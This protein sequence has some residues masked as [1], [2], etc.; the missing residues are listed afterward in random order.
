MSVDSSGNQT[1]VGFSE[2]ASISADRRVVT[3]QSRATNLVANDTNNSWDIFVHEL[4][5]TQPND[6]ISP[7]ITASA[8]TDSGADYVPDTW[9][10]EDVKVTLSA[11]DN[12]G[13][14]GLKDIR[15]SATGAQSISET[16]YDSQ[17]LPPI[18]TEG[19]MTLSYFATDNAGNQESP[20]KTLTVKIDK[21]APTLDTDNSDGS[22][23]ITPDNRETGVS[24]K[25]QPTATFSDEMDPSSLIA[26]ARLYRWNALKKEWQPVPVRVSVPVKRRRWPRTRETRRGCSWLTGSSRSPSPPV[27]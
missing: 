1:N 4:R 7:T 15:Y 17:N 8:S 24:R 26:S 6:C 10:N 19:T 12:E 23:S 27:R 5:A 20:A 25:I 9:T 13:D 14:S 22:D 2:S 21:S 16:I 11:Q 3:F 18:T